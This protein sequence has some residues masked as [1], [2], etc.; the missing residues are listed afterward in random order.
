MIFSH[1]FLSGTTL[2]YREI[3]PYRDSPVRRLVSLLFQF[4]F[5]CFPLLFFFQ[6]YGPKAYGYTAT[7]C[8]NACRNYRYFALQH[9]GWCCCGNDWNYAISLG[10]DTRPVCLQKGS[11]GSRMGAEWV[12]FCVPNINF[13]CT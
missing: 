10:P 5:R 12:F 3:G 13:L 11:D 2:I 1:F 4:N 8:V 9:W 6:P 7:K